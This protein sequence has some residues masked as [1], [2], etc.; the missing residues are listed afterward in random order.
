MDTTH[1]E[2]WIDC[3]SLNTV[4]LQESSKSYLEAVSFTFYTSDLNLECDFELPV[5]SRAQLFRESRNLKGAC[6]KIESE[7]V[8]GFLVAIASLNQSS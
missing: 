2:K 1:P 8:L 7:L 5:K 6:V 3:L 4:I